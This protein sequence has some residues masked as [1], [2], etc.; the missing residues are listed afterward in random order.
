MRRALCTFLL[1]FFLPLPPVQADTLP[2]QFHLDE[3]T[4]TSAGVYHPDGTLVRTLWRK[5]EH[6]PGTHTATWD[7]KN[8]AQQTATDG[9]YEIRLISHHARYVWEGGIGNTSTAPFGRTVHRGF[10]PVTDLTITGNDV[11]YITGYTEGDYDFRHFLTN[12]PQRVNDRWCWYWNPEEKKIEN[13]S[14]TI[15]SPDWNATDTD[16][17]WV[18]FASPWSTDSVTR[19]LRSG[20]GFIVAS[21]VSTRE[22][23]SFAQGCVIDNGPAGFFPFANGIRVGTM[24]GLSGLAVQKNGPLLAASV[25]PENKIYL[26]HKRTGEALGVIDIPSPGA[27]G[28]APNGDLW[29][30][31]GSAVLKI[32]TPASNPV[33]TNIATGLSAPIDLA[34]AQDGLLVAVVDGGASQQVKAWN[35]NGSAA[36]TLGVA[37]GYETN[38]PD[39]SNEKFLFRDRDGV[40]KGCVTF[41]PDGT[42][43]VGDAGNRRLLH[44]SASRQV[45]ETIQFQNI[46][47]S[48]SVNATDPTRVFCDY[49]EFAVDYSK[50]LREGWTLVRNWAGGLPESYFTFTSGLRQVTTLS[51]GRTYGLTARSDQPE[52]EFVELTPDGLRL[53]NIQLATNVQGTEVFEYFTSEGALRRATHF[54]YSAPP[55]EGSRVFFE[56]KP[57]TGFT[58]EGNPQWGNYQLLASA[59]AN[60][61]DPIRRCCGLGDPSV[62]I[63]S[64]GIIISFDPSKNN[65]WHLG[66]VRPGGTD[67]LWKASPS[68]LT[69]VPLDGLGSFGIGDGVNYPGNSALS[70]GR[71]VFFGYHGEFW[72]E[73]QAG[74][75]MHFYDNGLFIGQFGESGWGHEAFEITVP[76]RAGNSA[77]PSVVRVNGRVHLWVNDESQN[78][79]Q[80]WL[81]QGTDTVREY[82]GAGILGVSEPVLL[83]TPPATFPTGLLVEAGDRQAKLRWNPVQG[84]TSY[85]I[86]KTDRADG[87][88]QLIAETSGGTETTIENL[89]NGE[90]TWFAVA[91]TVADE[92]SVASAWVST[93]PASPKL[94]VERA[95]QFEQPGR[96]P[97]VYHI[98]EANPSIGE[99]ALI[100]LSPLLGNLSRFDVGSAG[101]RLFSWD[102]VEFTD[103]INFP[104]GDRIEASSGWKSLD[105][106]SLSYRVGTTTGSDRGLNVE[107]SSAPGI[108]EITPATDKVYYLTVVLPARFRDERTHR[109]TLVS[110]DLP[111]NSASYEVMDR[112]G[113]QHIHQFR[114]RG[115]SRLLVE[116]IDG[117]VSVNAV[118]LDRAHLLG[119]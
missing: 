112:P 84:A 52:R 6:R 113:V 18:Y 100:G 9:T 117:P 83:T 77:Y 65:G 119:E 46:S 15:Y 35:A 107:S 62:P 115:R 8:D 78:G 105:Y 40:V 47:Y 25:R 17:E 87:I 74:Q 48:V 43:W 95:G 7:G 73:T 80:R 49:L 4:T 97:G 27:C 24:P 20:P 67:W 21:K 41:A 3:R 69:N 56:E 33:T 63:T 114:F 42:F 16:G 103:A 31:G 14:S 89:T 37:G 22:S 90:K 81:I 111:E 102:P 66:G 54:N 106:L 23:V 55:P 118:F 104:E 32:E 2:F 64:S 96:E 79:P 5:V 51:N 36:W 71:H 19:E 34:V 44:Y 58:S 50:P 60:A 1:L 29:V 38:G 13:R 53:T 75:F 39:V 61:E 88:L 72:N 101:Y 59:P 26:M 116:A 12:D 70:L 94:V 110:V 57:L 85:R 92:E 93:T 82:S 10:G 108:L 98:T 86:Y 30:L 91:A 99:P 11:F 28:F 109:V 45:L 68:L 76:G